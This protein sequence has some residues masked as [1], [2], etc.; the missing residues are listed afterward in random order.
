MRVLTKLAVAI[1][2]G[3]ICASASAKTHP[4]PTD[5]ELPGCYFGASP[6]PLG[7]ELFIELNPDGTYNLAVVA[8]IG[9][10]DT[11]SGKWSRNAN[12]LQLLPEHPD[13]R[14]LGLNGPLLISRESGQPMLQYRDTR[15]KR[16]VKSWD[17]L[18][19][20]ES[21]EWLGRSHESK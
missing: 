8:D 9:P 3:G 6:V 12:H 4:I 16:T 7:F 20:V 18:K 1:V 10:I 2:L 5:S 21:C 19:R 15:G 13:K 17:K 11:A 14:P